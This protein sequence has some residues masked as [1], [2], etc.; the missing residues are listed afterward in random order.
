M[1]AKIVVVLILVAI[2]VSLGSALIYLIKDNGQSTRTAKALTVRIGL[3]LFLFL[4]LMLGVYTGVI[5][6]HGIYPIPQQSQGGNGPHP[7]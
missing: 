4:M 6:P 5:K 7:R 2:L 1:L 3:S